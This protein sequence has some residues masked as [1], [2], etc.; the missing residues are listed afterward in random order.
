MNKTL[1]ILASS[2]L[3]FASCKED[4]DAPRIDGV[5]YNMV[6]MPFEQAPCGYPGQT[7]CVRGEHLDNIRLLIVNGTDIDLRNTLEYQSDHSLTF[8]LPAGVSTTGDNIRVVT[9]YGKADYHFVVRPKS[10][11]PA[12]SSFSSTTLV[13]GATLAITGS[14]LTGATE[15]WLPL[16]FDGRVKCSFD[17]TQPNTDTKV[18]VK[19]P[20]DVRFATGRCEIVMEKQD[21]ERGQTYTEKVFSAKTNFIN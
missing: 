6:S 13:P 21:A 4:S 9:A 10:Q 19:V 14:N 16:A 3:L 20:A 17:E 11:Q 2:L 12:I 7:L 5:W 1:I 8:Q 15:I 18:Y